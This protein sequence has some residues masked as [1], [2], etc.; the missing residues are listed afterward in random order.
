MPHD[1]ESVGVDTTALE[2]D[3]KVDKLA[4]TATA[5]AKDDK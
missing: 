5:I 1:P 2:V 3:V 4:P